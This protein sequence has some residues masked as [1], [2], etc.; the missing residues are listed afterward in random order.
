MTGN[1]N[2]KK[3]CLIYLFFVIECPSNCTEYEPVCSNGIYQ[4]TFDNKCDA[5]WSGIN[6]TK[7]MDGACKNT[8]GKY[9]SF[10]LL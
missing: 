4:R 10:L 9:G 7:V 5:C 3:E 2:L 8:T 6:I 1:S